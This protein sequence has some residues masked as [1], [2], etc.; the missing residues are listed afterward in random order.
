MTIAWFYNELNFPS[1]FWKLLLDSLGLAGQ[2]D[3]LQT[4]VWLNV[5]VDNVVVK[6]ME[7]FLKWVCYFPAWYAMV[8][9]SLP[10][11]KLFKTMAAGKIL[12]CDRQPGVQDENLASPVSASGVFM[13][14]RSLQVCS[15]SPFMTSS[16]NLTHGCLL[17]K[18]FPDLTCLQHWH[19]KLKPLPSWLEQRV[20]TGC[21]LTLWG[22]KSGNGSLTI[23]KQIKMHFDL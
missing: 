9:A 6:Y 14:V 3:R 16:V 23:F 8:T 21:I 19:L 4:S 22:W 15:C 2:L 11:E 18:Y 5:P 20:L 10:G 1:A 17:R 12:R 7:H 13:E